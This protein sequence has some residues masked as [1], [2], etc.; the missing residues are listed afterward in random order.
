MLN[1]YRKF[2]CGAAGVLAPLTDALRGP[3][4]SIIWS[5]ALDSS[6]RHAKDLLASVPELAH[7]RPGAQISLAVDA[8]DSH[9]G[10]V[11]QQLLDGS[12][13]PLAFFSKK[14]SVA[15][16]KYSAFNRELFAPF[17]SLL[18]FGFL[19][20]VRAFTITNL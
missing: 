12:W 7:L 4:K 20:E 16:Q 14:L 1:F 10:S 8:F 9:V 6:F 13:A 2:L 3:G 15:E 18:H 19:L 5:L 11:L 17:F